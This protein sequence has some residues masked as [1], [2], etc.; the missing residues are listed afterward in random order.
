MTPMRGDF[1]R[2]RL[3]LRRE[4]QSMIALNW[5]ISATAFF[6]QRVFPVVVSF[7]CL[8]QSGGRIGRPRF[9]PG[10]LGSEE[11]RKGE[12]NSD[13][14]ANQTA[15]TRIWRSN[16]DRAET[17]P[18]TLT[19]VHLPLSALVRSARCGPSVRTA[20]APSPSIPAGY[21]ANL[22]LLVFRPIGSGS[23]QR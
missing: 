22:R 7:V 10:P 6:L 8:G 17:A 1:G 20:F 4:S 9:G 11:Q 5:G 16:P 19:Y 15:R 21:I 3:A 18:A 12:R 2:F 23:G 14:L 13:A